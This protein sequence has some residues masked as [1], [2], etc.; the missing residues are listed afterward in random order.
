MN[1]QMKTSAEIRIENLDRL[2]QETAS[3]TL[4]E[5]ADRCDVSSAYLSQV[6][7]K[8]PETKTGKPK[9]MGDSVAR[10][11]ENGMGKPTGWMDYDAGYVDQK[12]SVLTSDPLDN[13]PEYSKLP[14]SRFASVPL[15][16][17]GGIWEFVVNSNEANNADHPQHYCPPDLCTEGAFA[18]EV[19]TEAFPDDILRRSV[20]IIHPG[21]EWNTGKIAV[22]NTTDGMV[23]RRLVMDG[24]RK[25]LSQ[26]DAAPW[27][28][29]PLADTDRIVGVMVASIKRHA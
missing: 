19:D 29:K 3:K 25:M 4:R 18:L 23:L 9:N 26:H 22:V 16:G 8:I 15:L 28:A 2:V 11:L 24:D 12:I 7:N 1:K 14:G 10:K 21:A 13:P 20:L 5:L 27:L 6:R 17:W